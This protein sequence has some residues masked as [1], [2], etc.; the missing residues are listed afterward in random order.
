VGEVTG[1]P[2]PH[3]RPGDQGVDARGLLG[4]VDAVEDEGI[5]LHSLAVAR[6][7]HV[8]AAGWWAPYA[9]DGAP[10]VYSLSKSLTATAVGLLV[11]DGRFGVDDLVLDLLGVDPGAVDPR[12]ARV[13]VSHALAMT[14]GHTTD[15][16]YEVREVAAR[17]AAEG[18][19]DPLLAAIWSVPPDAE[20]GTVFAYNQPSTVLLARVVAQVAGMPLSD[21][22]HA[23]LLGPL[24]LPG[25]P[26]E[27]DPAGHEL[28]FTGAHVPTATIAALAQLHL[29]G[30]VLGGRRFLS[31]GWVT[32]ATRGQGPPRTD[33]ETNADWV[34]GY[35]YSFWQSR[36][37][38]RGD[39]AF[40]QYAV[41][42]P[43]QDTVVAVTGE[44]QD[45]QRVLDLLWDH[46][47]PAVSG[48]TLSAG[49]APGSA[50]ADERAAD[51]RAA[52]ERAADERAAD[53]R[54][55]VE[56]AECELATRLA[57]L[58]LV[59]PGSAGPGREGATFRRGRDSSLPDSYTGLEVRPSADGA[60]GHDWLLRLGRDGG[61]VE[62]PA[63]DGRWVSSRVPFGPGDLAVEAGAGWVGE[64]RFRAE[65]RLVETPHT[66]VLEGDTGSG[67]A[68]LG[69]RN[70]PMLGPDPALFVLP[71][72]LVLA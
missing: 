12:W 59:A 38:Y 31:E 63:G 35:G 47:L 15:S 29:D 20:P 14:L 51:E 43:E 68:R 66:L 30:G 65:L 23:R 18:H 17:L 36:H 24:G 10:L 70:V 32:E 55:E 34:C 9:P 37:G 41:V 21:L 42:L 11:D 46:V 4:F 62:V 5:E 2:L 67:E 72:G 26:W 53:E 71:G 3:S 50:V 25:I 16:I 28:G 39:G 19:R 40:G 58:A 1:I 57:S 60:A 52:D 33:G 6:H 45:M 44:T 13:Q 49:D 8:V 22:L 7:G 56:R 27:T 64:G 48:G 69:W 61:T 54:A